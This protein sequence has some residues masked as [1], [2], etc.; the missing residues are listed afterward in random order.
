MHS[1]TK[2]II[3]DKTIDRN[4]LIRQAGSRQIYSQLE[5][6]LPRSWDQLRC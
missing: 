4:E 1:K 6:K 5:I 3:A 2:M